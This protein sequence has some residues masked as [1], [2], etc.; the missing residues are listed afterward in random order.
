MIHYPEVLQLIESL[1]VWNNFFV[2]INPFLS[3]LLRI[4]VIPYI[5]EYVSHILVWNMD[6]WKINDEFQ[7]FK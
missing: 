2:N 6:G 7:N 5:T 1:K 4:Q 3:V